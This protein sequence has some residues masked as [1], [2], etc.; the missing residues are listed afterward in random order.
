[1]FWQIIQLAVVSLL[2]FY[3]S[4]LMFD[5][6]CELR[7]NELYKRKQDALRSLDG[8]GRSTAVI[9][10]KT[11]KIE[12]DYAAMAGIIEKKRKFVRNSI[13]RAC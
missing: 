1:M 2:A 10:A 3:V 4:A 8:V 5:F 7:M 11:F 9:K 13:L 6:F 12:M